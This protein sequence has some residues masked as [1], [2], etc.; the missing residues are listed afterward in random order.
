MKRFLNILL[1]SL[2]LNGK[3][4]AEEKLIRFIKEHKHMT[5]LDRIK[6]IRTNS[7]YL[8]D[9]NLPKVY[10]DVQILNE[11]G[12]PIKYTTKTTCE[13]PVDFNNDIKAWKKIVQLDNKKAVREA[14]AKEKEIAFQKMWQQRID[15]YNKAIAVH[16]KVY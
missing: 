13:R 6:A 12:S 15:N 14:K 11:D 1:S 4:E 16:M 2:T 3:A 5:L 8:P 7:D 10:T 9:Y